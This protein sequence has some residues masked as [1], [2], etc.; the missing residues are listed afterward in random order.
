MW[1]SSEITFSVGKY[2][3]WRG[4]SF[5]DEEL[6]FVLSVYGKFDLEGRNF[7]RVRTI[8]HWY[9]GS[10]R[11]QF[12][13]HVI[14]M[15][16]WQDI[17]INAHLNY[18]SSARVLIWSLICSHCG[19]LFICSV[20]LSYLIICWNIICLLQYDDEILSACVYTTNEKLAEILS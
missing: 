6:Q 16:W 1:F 2:K 8:R 4:Y 13:F 9:N 12:C 19:H 3:G 17:V 10:K 5:P 11:G 20:T 15:Y 18:F 14:C 7:L